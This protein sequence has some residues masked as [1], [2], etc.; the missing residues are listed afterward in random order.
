MLYR[1]ETLRVVFFSVSRVFR[2]NPGSIFHAASL[3]LVALVVAAPLSAE[4][5]QHSA[6]MAAHEGYFREHCL[7]LQAGQ[8][9]DFRF[10]TPNPVNFNIHHH[11][12]TDTTYPVR[13]QVE[14]EL[15]TTLPIADSGEY[16]FMWR[17]LADY[18]AAYPIELTYHLR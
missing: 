6:P 5:V 14:S 9:L 3:A 10:T 13:Q 16:C 7:E 2:V 4:Q 1:F 12:E 18:P 17:N 11:S 15:T 8:K